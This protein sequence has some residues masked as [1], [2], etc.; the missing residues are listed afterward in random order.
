MPIFDQ[1]YQHWNGT[2][3]GQGWRW[4]AITR[5]GVRVGMKSLVMRIYLLLALAPALVLVF[6]LCIWGLVERKAESVSSLMGILS[7]LQPEIL[8]HPQH[9]RVEIW[10][11]FYSQFLQIELYFSIVLILIVGPNLISQDL[12]FNALPLYFSRPLR[13]ID[14]FAGKLGIITAFLAMVMIVPAI[15]GYA[16]GLL[17]SLDITILRDTFRVLLASIV[18]GLVIAVSA[19]LLMLAMSS[20]SRSSRYTALFWLGMCFL[21]ISLAFVLGQ[22][23][24]EQRRHQYHRQMMNVR[25][26]I[27]QDPAERRI[28]MRELQR[29]QGKLEDEFRAAELHAGERDWRPLIS[30]TANLERVGEH[31]LGTRKCWD[32]L[33]L[34]KSADERDRFIYDHAGPQYPWYWSAIVLAALFGLSAWILNVRVRSLDRLK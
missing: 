11:L 22:V 1:G 28:Q 34:L 17:F 20:L 14:Y 3:G 23:N 15:V 6:M 18:Y 33:S 5:H 9:F 32:R 2:L 29:A 26:P 30:Y 4:L 31:L 24:Q 16:L 10:T 21:G 7:F 19:G 12:R 13:R 8:A 27:S 25:P